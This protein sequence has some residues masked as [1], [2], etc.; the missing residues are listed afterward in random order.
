MSFFY[1]SL[2]SLLRRPCLFQDGHP[3]TGLASPHEMTTDGRGGTILTIFSAGPDCDGWYQCTAFNAAGSA[4]TRARVAVQ[5]P[6]EPP[7]AQVPRLDLPRPGRI[8]E[9]E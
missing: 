4:I 1:P 3:L 9:P 6:P 8:I 2:T 5:A 7:P